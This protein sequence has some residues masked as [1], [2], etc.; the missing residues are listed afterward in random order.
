MKSWAVPA[1]GIV[2]LEYVVALM[3]GWRV[4][5]HY[6]IP[7]AAYLISAL[8]IISIGLFALLAFR[9]LESRNGPAPLAP[10]RFYSFAVGVLLVALQFAVLN[11]LKIMLPIAQPFWADQAL[12]DLDAAIFGTDPWRI[13]HALFGWA[14]S[15]IDRAYVTWAPLKFAALFALVLLPD[16]PRKTRALLA[17]FLIVS[18]GCL[19]QYLLPAAGPVFYSQ[20][21]LGNRF[22]DLPAGPWVATAADYLWQDYL[23][24]GGNIGTGI[25]AMP[26]LHVAIAAWMALVLRSYIP[27][28][29]AV[30]WAYFALILIGSVHLG[31][32]YAVDGLIGAGGALLVWRLIGEPGRRWVAFR[33]G[34]PVQA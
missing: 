21:G 14:S 2:A 32:H 16:G 3:I 12:A 18:I 24:G 25:S 19:G 7:F 15:L 13:S 17:Y 26:S 27:K 1:A 5:F 8:T 31:W 22:V 6:S 11:W 34:Q 30:G 9:L 33:P 10:G 29:Q 28:V 23:R 4:G 20:I